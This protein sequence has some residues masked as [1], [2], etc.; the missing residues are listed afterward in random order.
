MSDSL[1]AS[2]DGFKIVP[3]MI[4]YY[5]ISDFPKRGV[6]PL[7]GYR[8]GAQSQL[9]V[10]RAIQSQEVKSVNIA[11]TVQHYQSDDISAKELPAVTVLGARNR[12]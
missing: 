2:A 12:S 10:D 6:T 3:T 4:P 8:Q 9:F 1:K 11:C 7:K 5:C